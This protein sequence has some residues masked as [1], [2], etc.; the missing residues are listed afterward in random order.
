MLVLELGMLILKIG[1]V[2]F[3][4]QK[5]WDGGRYITLINFPMWKSNLIIKYT[6][7]FSKLVR[8]Q[9]V[10]FASNRISII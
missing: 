5:F 2:G 9:N 8:S 3:K 1:N 6:G 7:F 4:N 10:I